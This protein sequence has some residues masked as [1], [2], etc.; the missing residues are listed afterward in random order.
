MVENTSTVTIEES[1]ECSFLTIALVSTVLSQ[2]Y[3]SGKKIIIDDMSN[4]KVFS[5]L[6]DKR[7]ILIDKADMLLSELLEQEDIKI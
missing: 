1:L 7:Y 6:R 4:P 2:S 3:Y 5:E